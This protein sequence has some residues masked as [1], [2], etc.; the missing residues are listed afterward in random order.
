ML[1]PRTD[2]VSARTPT[3]ETVSRLRSVERRPAR[4]SL[5]TTIPADG[6]PLT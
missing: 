2:V 1:V 6:N 4:H 5:P 3:G